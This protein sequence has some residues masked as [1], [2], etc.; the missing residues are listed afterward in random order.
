M[1]SAPLY[2]IDTAP[3]APPEM[4]PS[5]TAS[6]RRQPEAAPAAPQPD[7]RPPSA[8]LPFTVDQAQQLALARIVLDGQIYT[9]RIT[10]QGKLILTK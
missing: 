2:L 5:E 6:S 3:P 7:A 10:R 4:A 8:L 1:Q 9:L